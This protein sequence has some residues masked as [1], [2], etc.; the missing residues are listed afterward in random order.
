MIQAKVLGVQD[1]HPEWGLPLSPITHDSLIPQ[2]D[3]ILV[4]R[5]RR[6]L[7]VA[8]GERVLHPRF[9][10]AVHR[11]S[12]IESPAERHV[13]AAL[14][15]EAIE[16]FL[17][18][19]DV[20]RVDVLESL[21]PEEANPRNRLRVSVASSQSRCEFEMLWLTRSTLAEEQPKGAS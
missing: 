12:R 13:A 21:T 8:P 7:E 9:G 11:M 1:R 6:V 18:D 16:E 15:E 5:L 19:V 17:P 3:E 14:I 20:Q 4:D 2:R 10:C